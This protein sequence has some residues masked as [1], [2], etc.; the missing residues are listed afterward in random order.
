MESKPNIRRIIELQATILRFRAIGRENRIPPENEVPENDVEH[1]YSLALVGWY[2]AQFFPHLNQEKVLKY[3]LAHDLIEIHAGDT[4][5][6][7]SEADISS[8]QAREA[9]AQRQ[10]AE[11]W[12]D[13]A[14]LHEHIIEYE[15]KST[16]EAKFIYSLDK[17]MPALM[18]YLGN[19]DVWKR[20]GVS[21]ERFKRE[22]ESK[23][24][25]SPEV[26]P[27]Y[28]ELLALIEKDVDRY[29]PKA[30]GTNS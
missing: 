13:F 20:H 10:L 14:D 9:A 5:A 2:L 7:G 8:K 4:F 22:K 29:F 6:Y 24:P 15:D 26:Y 30:D 21:I 11:E 28:H 18:N 16:N 12:Q 27:Y 3:A 17:L 1:S 19:G 23:M 25:V